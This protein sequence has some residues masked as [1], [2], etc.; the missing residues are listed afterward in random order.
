[1]PYVDV[2][3]QA[4]AEYVSPGPFDLPEVRAWTR[5]Q[6]PNVGRRD[7]LS[8]IGAYVRDLSTGEA[9]VTYGEIAQN[10]GIERKAVGSKIDVLETYGFLATHH[11][12]DSKGYIVSTT[13]ILAG[14]YSNWMTTVEVGDQDVTSAKYRQEQLLL[15]LEALAAQV[16]E[17]GGVPVVDVPNRDRTEEREINPYVPNRDRTEEREKD[18]SLCTK[19][20]HRDCSSLS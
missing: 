6:G 3:H 8:E 7:V 16:I 17:L 12:R 1:M 15:Q 18:K 4:A 11:N 13:Y 20:G 10:L 19:M 9:T 5:R 2:V 14:V